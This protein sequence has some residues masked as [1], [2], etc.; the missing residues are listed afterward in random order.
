MFFTDLDLPLLPS[1]IRY[2]SDLVYLGLVEECKV[3]DA[4]S[5]LAGKV[6]M[7]PSIWPTSFGFGGRC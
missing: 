3:D 4:V 2:A 6:C 5:D 7:L 1:L